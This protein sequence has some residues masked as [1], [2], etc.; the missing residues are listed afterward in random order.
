MALSPDEKT[1]YL[2]NGRANEVA[3]IDLAT[4]AVTATIPV[5]ERPWG[6]AL[7]PDGRTLYTANG[8]SGSISVIDVGS[9]RVTST[10]TVGGRPYTVL[11]VR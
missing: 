4:H 2:A 11:L 8:R 9:R 6:V 3:I 1:L 7:S 5:G 10:F